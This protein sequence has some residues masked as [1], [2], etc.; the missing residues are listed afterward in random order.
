MLSS[1]RRRFLRAA[2]RPY[3]RSTFIRRQHDSPHKTYFQDPAQAPQP[4]APPAGT[5]SRGRTWLGWGLSGFTAITTGAALGFGASLT[6]ITWDYLQDVFE[7]GSEEDQEMR[8]QI[9]EIF[10]EHVGVLDIRADPDYEEISPVRHLTIDEQ[11]HSLISGSLNGTRGI[12]WKMFWSEKMKAIHIYVFFG[13]GTE[14]WPDVVHGGMLTTILDEAMSRVAANTF[15]EKAAETSRLDVAF[16]K[17][18]RPGTIYQIR[19]HPDDLIVDLKKGFATVPDTE[20]R[21]RSATILGAILDETAEGQNTRANTFVEA[22]GNYVASSTEKL[23]SL[24][25]RQD[26]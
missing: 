26:R 8:E 1:A 25:E 24:T 3:F 9:E 22:K 17:P 13:N 16:V 14:G 15:P 7:I 18:V 21:K 2:S 6:L 11:P 19:A 23:E 10:D 12:I 20:E 4:T 5:R